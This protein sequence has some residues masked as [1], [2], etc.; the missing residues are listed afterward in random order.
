M[1]WISVFQSPQAFCEGHGYL[2]GY[3]TGNTR[4]TAGRRSVQ[5]QEVV[6][7]DVRLN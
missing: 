4:W 1:F 3:A 6:C 7:Y 2:F 5:Q